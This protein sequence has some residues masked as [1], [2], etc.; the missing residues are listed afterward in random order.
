MV[1][2]FV[3]MLLGVFPRAD[4]TLLLAVPERESDRPFGLQTESHELPG[5]VDEHHDVD[6]V[7]E[8]T[9]AEVL[10]VEMRTE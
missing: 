9:R 5:D 1:V 2:E 3:F 8:C 10:R 6:A 7:V 4:Q